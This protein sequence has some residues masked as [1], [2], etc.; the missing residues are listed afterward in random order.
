MHTN[1]E[2]CTSCEKKLEEAHPKLREWF[3]AVK[4]RYINAH[5]SCAF[6]NQ[7]DQTKVYL[8]KKSTLRWPNSK[9]NFMKDGKPCAMALD[10]FQIDEDG[11][12]RWSPQFFAKLNADN[13]A[14]KI[15]LRWGGLFKSLGDYCHFELKIP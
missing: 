13:E 5:V 1:T 8:E 14:A 9:H 10:L 4:K 6:R 15:D 2:V 7:A 12:A 11:L 3:S